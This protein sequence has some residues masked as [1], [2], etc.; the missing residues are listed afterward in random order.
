MA[1]RGFG[2]GLWTVDFVAAA[3]GVAMALAGLVLSLFI[4]TSY[5]AS[6]ATARSNVSR[7]DGVYRTAEQIDIQYNTLQAQGQVLE[8]AFQLMSDK[9]QARNQRLEFFYTRS[10][11][12]TRMIAY[13][14]EKA[15][16]EGVLAAY[17]AE[18]DAYA[19]GD[20][21]ASDRIA[22]R[23]LEVVQKAV[24]MR[25]G[26]VRDIRNEEAAIEGLLGWR[27]LTLR[28]G[29][30]LQL[31]GLLVVLSGIVLQRRSSSYGF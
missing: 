24:S 15:E 21:V 14:F 27:D 2:Q 13:A 8:V 5:D 3:G 18:F 11:P 9:V 22:K 17:Q 20:D 29:G 19:A 28:I 6:I 25:Q 7:L 30:G 1:R 16:G 4:A 12:I 23:E 10:L 26:L 31:L